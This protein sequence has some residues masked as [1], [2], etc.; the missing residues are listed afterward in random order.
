M[1]GAILI[2]SGVFIVA[3]PMLLVAFVSALLILG[4]IVAIAIV[5]RVKRFQDEAG[6]LDDS[7][8]FDGSFWNQAEKVFH[9]GRWH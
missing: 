2:L 8:P 5:Y 6:C 4:G 9:R 7:E 3:F 1:P